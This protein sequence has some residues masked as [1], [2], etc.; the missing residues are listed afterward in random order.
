MPQARAPRDPG[1][2]YLEELSSELRRYGLRSDVIT[3]GVW[4]RLR[5]KGPCAAGGFADTAFEDHVLVAEGPGGRWSYWWPWVE[6]ICDAGN[7]AKAAELVADAFG[8]EGPPAAAGKPCP[9][10]EFRHP[11]ASASPPR[12][13]PPSVT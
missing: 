13:P 7:T 8:V 4:P 3:S 1:Q 5:I 11:R 6:E 12:R 9:I 10:L 2:R